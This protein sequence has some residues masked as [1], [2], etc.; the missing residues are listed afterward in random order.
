MSSRVLSYTT[1]I[2]SNNVTKIL[3]VFILELL[4]L[5]DFFA[6]VACIYQYFFRT[7]Q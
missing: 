2:G 3:V 4:Q 7:L 1:D 5:R 6:K